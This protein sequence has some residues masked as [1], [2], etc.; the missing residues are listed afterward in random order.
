[1]EN[2]RFPVSEEM[3]RSLEVEIGESY[4]EDSPLLYT[5]DK[6]LRLDLNEEIYLEKTISKPL[7]SQREREREY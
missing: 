6:S 5:S 7:F 4:C 1:M 2:R 3:R